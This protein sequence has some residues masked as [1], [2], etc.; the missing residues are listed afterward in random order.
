MSNKTKNIV[1]T[2]TFVAFIAAFVMMC[3]YRFFNPV[4]VS[5]SERRP[6]AQ[7]P[8]D[9]TWEGIVDKEV[10]N[11]FE[12]YAV[13]QFPLREFFRTLKAKFAL[14]ILGLKE[15]NGLAVQDGY[16]VKVEKEFNQELLDYSVGRLEYIYNKYLADNGGDK[17]VS[18][19]PDKNYFLGQDYGYPSGDYDALAQLVQEKLPGMTYVDIFGALEL[20]DYY[21]TDTHWS[22]DKI[23]GVVD[24]LAEAMG[25]SDRLS[26]KFDQKELDGGFKGVYYGQSALRPNPDK[27]VYLTNEILENCTVYD[28]ETGKTY[29][30]YNFDAF[31]ESLTNS[32]K[33]G[34][35][36]FLSGTRALLRIDNPSAT[37][38]EELIV[39]RDS[40]GSSLLPLLAE[41]Y[42]SIYIV[43]IR[44]VMPDMLDRLINFEGKDVLM[45]YSPLVLNQ[46]AFK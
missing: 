26:G 11:D 23:L 31:T 29:G 4:D 39:F 30:I 28:Y 44:Y 22:Q 20:E 38:Q 43:D 21:H 37:T 18:I 2:I 46:K 36:F 15:N 24:V 19:V 5:E 12:D 6:L 41:G 10:I 25:I 42:K 3:G 40:F 16:I 32:K 35:D 17:F 33:D 14:N 45:I 1:V 7:F 8:S 34:Y 27:L 13:D 9:I